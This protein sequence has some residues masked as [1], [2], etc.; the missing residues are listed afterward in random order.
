[1]G[2][3][4]ESLLLGL[5]GSLGGLAE[6]LLAGDF[7]DDTDSDGLAHIADSEATKRGV[8]GESLDNHGLGGHELDE[9]GILGLDVSGGILSDGTGTLVDLGADLLELAGNMASMAIKDGS[10]SVHDLSGM[11]E[12]NNLS[13]EHLGVGAGVVLG[14]GS[15]VA[16]LDILDGQV[17]DVEAN[18]VTG[19]GSLD[20]LVMHLDGFDLSGGV[21]GSESDDHTGLE[22]T[23][24]DATDGHCSDTANLVDV[25]EGKSEG[26]VC[27]SLGGSK[28]VEEVKEARSSVPGHVRGG[29]NHVVTNPAGDGDE[30]DVGNVVADLLEEDGE[31]SLDLIESIL[32]VVD[33]GVVHLVDGDDHQLDTH[34]LV[35]YFHEALTVGG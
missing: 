30:G 28:V 17:L 29:L 4:G 25:L 33:T 12:D 5:L 16:S 3:R 14:V 7:L 2:V 35:D 6:L 18:V 20:L 19:V 24:L 1:M 21:H 8:G 22:G 34:S 11:V 32:G 31:L 23:G 10:V 13:D 15:D 27:G 26:L 9:S